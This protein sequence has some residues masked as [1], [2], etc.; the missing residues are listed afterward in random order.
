MHRFIF[1]FS[2]FICAKTKHKT[3]DT[4]HKNGT[5]GRNSRNRAG[6]GRGN[7]TTAPASGCTIYTECGWHNGGNRATRGRVR[8]LRGGDRTTCSSNANNANNAHNANAPI[9]TH[10]R[11]GSVSTRV[12]A[13]M[14]G[15][16]H[17]PGV[18]NVDHITDTRTTHTFNSSR[19]IKPSKSP[20]F[21]RVRA[22]SSNPTWG[23]SSVVICM[24]T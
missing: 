22:E 9:H 23:S 12:H 5:N 2:F 21:M 13:C 20:F 10:R 18:S 17:F 1:S 7:R 8:T 15:R 3:Q 19:K 24:C 14:H 16:E 11:L 4:K 6:G